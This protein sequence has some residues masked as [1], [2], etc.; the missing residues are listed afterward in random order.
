MNTARDTDQAVHLAADRT[1]EAQ[2][3][4]S[5]AINAGE[6]PAIDDVEVV[7]HRAEDV[8]V[9]TRQAADEAERGLA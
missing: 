7:V 5:E 1:L 9:L 8:E 4:V 6:P 2:A 3:V